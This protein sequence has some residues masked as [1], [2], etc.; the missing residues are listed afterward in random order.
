MMGKREFHS[1]LLNSI[2]HRV[3]ELDSFL[4]SRISSGS[5]RHHF[6]SVRMFFNGGL[7]SFGE[8]NAIF[9]IFFFF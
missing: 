3:E 1:M 5:V 2:F 6:D 8:L 4:Y 9:I 7:G